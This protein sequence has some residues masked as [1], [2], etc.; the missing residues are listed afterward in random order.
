MYCTACG[1]NHPARKDRQSAAEL[2]TSCTAGGWNHPALINTAP[3]MK[4]STMKAMTKTGADEIT[5]QAEAPR[6]RSRAKA[7]ISTGIDDIVAEAASNRS[8][9][10]QGSGATTSP[11]GMTCPS[12]TGED[13]SSFE[14]DLSRRLQVVE[15][16]LRLQSA[17]GISHLQKAEIAPES[18]G[19]RPA[20]GRLYAT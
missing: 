5:A 10:R 17:L 6:N 19:L 9:T 16:S 13:S 1:W 4:A 2:T 11:G 7:T 18:F 20:L 15:E 14:L 8:H 12:S 3:T